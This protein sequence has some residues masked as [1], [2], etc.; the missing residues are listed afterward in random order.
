MII[1]YNYDIQVN[2]KGVYND[3]FW[4]TFFHEVGHILLHGKKERFIDLSVH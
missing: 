2:S 1:F 4:F 3:S